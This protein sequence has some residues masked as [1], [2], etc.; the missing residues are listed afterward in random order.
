MSCE[1]IA[2]IVLAWVNNHY[3]D[4]ETNTKLY[5]FLEIFDDR[6]QN[7]E[8]EVNEIDIQDKIIFVIL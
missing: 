7:H 1:H 3:N 5:E 2:R 4:F 6:L 8:N